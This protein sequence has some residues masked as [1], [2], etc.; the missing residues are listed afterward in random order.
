M[1][2]KTLNSIVGQETCKEVLQT[3]V[4]SSQISNSP[5]PHI[6]LSSPAGHG[7]TSI[8]QALSNDIGSNLFT[9]NCA[10]IG[11]SDKL[12]SIIEEMADKDIL[13]MD[14]IHGLTKKTCESL[15]TVLEDFCYYD[16]GY[17][18]KTPKITIIGASTEIGRLPLPL[19]S[20]FKFTASLVP[21]TDDELVEVCYQICE[22]KGFKLNK[23]LARVIAKTCRGTPRSVVS[24][25][26][27]IYAYMT[28]NGLK[29]ISGDKLLDIIK[30]QGI[31]KD[32]LEEHDMAYL[33]CLYEN[34]GSL[35][36]N[37]LS[38]KLMID[39]ENIKVLIEPH[40]FKLG[41]IEVAT[42]KGRSLTRSGKTYVEKLT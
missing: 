32:G 16:R 41:F 12:F 21:Y 25:T 40:L 13:F 42:A 1:R 38:S 28:G 11:K 35:S 5:V 24:R 4:K 31:N 6:L 27:W 3:L 37:A 30:L 29:T 10:N 17:K 9:V 20:R 39:Q 23:S 34:K 8:A 7:K 26:E 33:K 19:K 15:Y 2:P 36:L 14:E 22:E 18:V